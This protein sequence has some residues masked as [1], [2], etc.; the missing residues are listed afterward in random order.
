MKS[1]RDIESPSHVASSPLGGLNP[2]WKL[3]LG[4]LLILLFMFVGGPLSKRIPGAQRLGEVIDE[5][6][7]KATAIYYTDIE[8]SAD[9]SEY[10]RHC[11]EYSPVTE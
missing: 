10:I 8:E 7:L 11:L 6:D 5:R 9:G 4:V 3:F 2:W 1:N